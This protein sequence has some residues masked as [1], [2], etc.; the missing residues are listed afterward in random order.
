MTGQP[1]LSAPAERALAAAGIKTL[2]D[3]ANFT[4]A[5]IMLLHGMG[6]NAMGKV[7]A[8]L[9]ENGLAFASEQN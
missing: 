3:F 1:R 5:E 8:A 4:E 7:K 6:P 9:A 2:A